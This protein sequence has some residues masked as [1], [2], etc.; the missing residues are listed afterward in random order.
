MGRFRLDLFHRLCVIHL[1][2][3]PLRERR[4]DVPLIVERQLRLHEERTGRRVRIAPRAMD[5]LEAY[6]WPGN[7]RELVNLLEG[8]I[9]VLPPGEELF[10]R[11]PEMLLRG[12]P[13]A[14]GAPGEREVL[15]LEELERRACE[16]TLARFQG[17]VARAASA[18]GV[19]KGTLYAKIKRYGLDAPKPAAAPEP[20]VRARRVVGRV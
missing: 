5:L 6:D 12:R 11:P 15:S 14:G 13:A 9:G 18:L 3:P 2:L 20:P 19:A 1:H 16:E 17:N 8:E 7:V 4:G 10:A